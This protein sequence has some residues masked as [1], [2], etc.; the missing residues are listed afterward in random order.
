MSGNVIFRGNLD[1]VRYEKVVSRD[2][3]VIAR[4]SPPPAK[5]SLVFVQPY[6]LDPDR[7]NTSDLQ[8][9][10][11]IEGSGE[12]RVGAAGGNTFSLAETS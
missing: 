5:P 9:G 8:L 6:H 11:T 12:P 1:V 10:Q 4:D 2:N 7:A 3:L